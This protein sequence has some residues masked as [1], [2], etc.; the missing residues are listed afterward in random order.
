MLFGDR[1]KIM[2]DAVFWKMQYFL[3]ISFLYSKFAQFPIPYR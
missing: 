2:H 1:Y 3:L